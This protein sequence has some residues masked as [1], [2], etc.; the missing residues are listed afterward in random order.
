MHISH[1][2]AN[3][4]PGTPVYTFVMKPEEQKII[5]KAVAGGIFNVPIRVTGTQRLELVADFFNLLDLFGWDAGAF[6]FKSRDLFE[7]EGFD[8]ATGEP[9]VSVDTRFGDVIP[10]G[11]EP[12][13]FQAQLGVRYSF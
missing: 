2:L 8:P 7:A 11:F 13:Q 1:P 3:Q 5:R 10:S 4:T 6:N 12:F 9:I